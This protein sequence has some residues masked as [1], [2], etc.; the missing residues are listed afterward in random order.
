MGQKRRLSAGNKCV[1][2]PSGA[3][4]QGP[5]ERQLPHRSV[6]S[7]PAKAPKLRKLGANRTI[8]VTSSR[9]PAVCLPDLFS[10]LLISGKRE[11][12]SRVNVCTSYLFFLPLFLSFY[13]HI[14][15][16]PPEDFKRINTMTT[17]TV[18]AATATVSWSLLQA[19]HFGCAL[20]TEPYIFSQ[21][22]CKI[23]VTIPIFN[24]AQGHK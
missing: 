21:Q 7:T 17:P 23:R 20:N 24:R 10:F 8:P 1:T 16:S 3:L 19:T 22:I 5:K 11:S 15:N 14:L 12:F 6:K 2:L 9:G 4:R 13:I 18:T